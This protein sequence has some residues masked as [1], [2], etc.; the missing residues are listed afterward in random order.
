MRAVGGLCSDR[1][2]S[3]AAEARLSFPPLY[4]LFTT[5]LTE[6][7]LLLMIGPLQNLS[8]QDFMPW[9]SMAVIVAMGGLWVW[10]AGRNLDRTRKVRC[11]ACNYRGP[12]LIRAL[13]YRGKVD[14]CPDCEG[15]NLIPVRP[16]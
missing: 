8:W 7:P 9:I 4:R 14:L 6:L 11:R 16:R 2:E 5:P 1:L 3:L 13:P 15:E 12:P 10:Y